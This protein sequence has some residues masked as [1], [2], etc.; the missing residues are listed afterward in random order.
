MNLHITYFEKQLY[1]LYYFE[2]NRKHLVN[3][4]KW[5]SNY[6]PSKC[7]TI[8]AFTLTEHTEKYALHCSYFSLHNKTC[9]EKIND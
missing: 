5:D 4:E 8:V 6:T 3:T 9:N 1:I 7:E 2:Q